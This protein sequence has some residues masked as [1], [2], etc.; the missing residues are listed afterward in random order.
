MRQNQFL[1]FLYLNFFYNF[2][3]KRRVGNLVLELICVASLNIN[4]DKGL[5]L[6][7]Y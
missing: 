6:K 4:R 5:A 3:F 2:S 1:V 7:G